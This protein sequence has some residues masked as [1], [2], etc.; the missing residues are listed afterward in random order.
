MHKYQ[1]LLTEPYPDP[2]DKNW[3]LI[4]AD[5]NVN[6]A[7]VKEN[8]L[9]SEPKEEDHESYF[10]HCKMHSDKAIM[11]FSLLQLTFFV[12][13]H[14]FSCLFTFLSIIWYSKFVFSV[15]FRWK[16]FRIFTFVFKGLDLVLG[17]STAREVY[18]ILSLI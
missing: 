10:A 18:L 2:R 11:H 8:G 4:P 6:N 3:N 15:V 1:K 14:I 13:F 5:R 17:F 16:I 9:L 12:F 7:Y